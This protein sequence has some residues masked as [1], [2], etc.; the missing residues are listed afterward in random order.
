MWKIRH[1]G[2]IVRNASSALTFLDGTQLGTKQICLAAWSLQNLQG[3]SRFTVL[4]ILRIRLDHGSC[5]FLTYWLDF[6]ACLT[7][8]RR[9]VLY[10]LETMF[11]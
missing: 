3:L 9:L 4:V 1:I 2:S 8:V 5:E 6:V 10:I 11:P 7:F